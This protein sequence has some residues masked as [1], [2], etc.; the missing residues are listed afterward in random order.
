MRD[1]GSHWEVVDLVVKDD[2]LAKNS[3]VQSAEESWPKGEAP[4]RA[5]SKAG[6]AGT[7]TIGGKCG[8]KRPR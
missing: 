1:E 6:K 7:R 3:N 8:R 2:P 5:G 4:R